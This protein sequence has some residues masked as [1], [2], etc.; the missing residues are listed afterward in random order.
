MIEATKDS[1][2][3][4][5]TK[6]KDNGSVVKEIVGTDSIVRPSTHFVGKER[7]G[8]LQDVPRMKIEHESG[9]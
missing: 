9:T 7:I 3:R 6:Q 8:S 5:T 4:R 1:V 2:T